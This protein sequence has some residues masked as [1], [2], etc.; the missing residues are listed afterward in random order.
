M[1]C[2]AQCLREFCCRSTNFRKIPINDD[3]ENCELLHALADEEPEK[4]ERKDTYDYLV[5]GRDNVSN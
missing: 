5:V 1:D 4:L 2:A 3:R